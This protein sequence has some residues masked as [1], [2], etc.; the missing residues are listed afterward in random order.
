[1][2]TLYIGT[3]LENVIKKE[4]I[5]LILHN[6]RSV[7]NVGAI[8]RTADAAGVSK[9]YITGYTPTPLDRFGN[10]RRDFHKTALGAEEFIEWEHTK[11]IGP[12]LK[13][14]KKEGVELIA[15]EQSRKSVDY[16]KM[17]VKK[18]TA[19]IVGNEVRGLSKSILD[20]VDVVA[21]IPQRGKKESLNVSVS[22]GIFLFRVLN[23]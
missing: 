1:M 12:V 5:V 15:L 23:I 14:L 2:S 22:L 10:K 20:K 7:I 19:I 17:K 18:P 3:I 4:R 16:K 9:I 11:T 6:I 13:K 21:E 8:F